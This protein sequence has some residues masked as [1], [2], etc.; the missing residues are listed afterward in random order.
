MSKCSQIND[1]SDV[2]YKSLLQA[3]DKAALISITDA[4]GN[5][6]HANDKFLEISQYS[7]EI[8]IGQN[9]RILKSNLQSQ[10]IFDDLWNTI[11]KGTVWRGE[12]QNRS[13]DGSLYWVDTMIFPI[14]GANGK[15]QKYISFRF[16]ITERKVIENKIRETSG[17]TRSLI[18]ASLDPLVT[19]NIEGSITDVNQATIDV[20]GV[21]RD[22]LIGSDFSNY[23]VEPEMARAGYKQ[24]FEKGS[25]TNY[26][27]TIHHKNGKLTDVLYNAS[28]YKD[29]YGNILGVFAAARDVTSQKL[30]EKLITE[31]RELELVRAEQTKT[32]ENFRRMATVVRDSNDAITIQDLEGNILA[33]NRGAEVMYGYKEAEALTMNIVDTVP[34]EYQA[35]ARGFLVSLKRGELVPNLETKRKHKN[36]KIIEVWLTNTK[37]TDDKGM[38][39]GIATTERDITDRKKNEMALKLSNET[40]ESRVLERTEQL[41]QAVQIRNNFISIASHELKTPLTSLMLQTQLRKRNL[42]K[43]AHVTFT[44]EQLTKMFDTD[45]QQL[46]RITHL[47]DDMLDI[48]R[49]S[50]G[51]LSINLNRFDLC[52][53]VKELV[54][55][56]KD[57][58]LAAG[59]PVT[60]DIC[61]PIFGN[62]D[63]FRIE[64]VIVN[65]LT[66]ALRYGGKNPISL[67]VKALKGKAQIIVRDQGL[68]IAKENHER[69]FQMFERAISESE[70]SGLG[71]GLFIV[72][73]I[74]KSHQGTIRL[75]SELGQGAAFF[76]ELPTL[77]ENKEA[78]PHV[79]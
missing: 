65:L 69:I 47:I 35:E 74:L 17:Y 64:Q 36:G 59:C 66:N 49:I 72:S 45:E 39:T 71:L 50:T 48:S 19:I 79:S 54:D 67:Q 23:F 77:E 31:K 14:T 22:S 20:T 13:K 73:Q 53:L 42:K 18:E 7:R 75:E 26:P 43:G 25:V 27:L 33:W 2:E 63:Q 78:K 8:L 68:G 62:W 29:E 28:I 44:T 16:L 34:T 56:T 5:I 12:I 3:L 15:P 24:A 6:L 60:I 37:L 41:N 30:A 70:V 52:E 51:K 21:P 11:S 4:K 38:L 9:H 57:Q 55:R 32:L 40:L 61:E 58:F 76:V 1:Q 10:S 46:A